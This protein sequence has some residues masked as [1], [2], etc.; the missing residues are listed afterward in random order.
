MDFGILAKQVKQVVA[1]NSPTILTAI[2]VTGTLVTAYLTG[3]AAFK[4]ANVIRDEQEFR[5]R[6]IT[7]D[8]VLT[9]DQ[10]KEA[11]LSSKDKFEVTWK[12]YVPAVV[13]A[14]LTVT[15]IICANRIGTRRAAALATAYKLSEK[16]YSEYKEKVLEKIGPEK[17]KEI[18][19]EVAQDRINKNPIDRRE[20]VVGTGK[21]RCFDTWTNRYFDSSVIAIEAAKNRINNQINNNI[22]ASLSDF[23]HE[24]GLSPTAESD[25]IGWNSDKLMELEIDTAMSEDGVTPCVTIGF[26]VTPVRN[27]ANFH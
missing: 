22:Y 15:T 18:R 3:N 10:A 26:N 19:K 4:A 14:G 11:T 8:P 25:D 16:V 17:E 7:E 1:D 23:Y 5:D 2:S 21:V 6:E 9:T 24:I 12:L 27:Y 13:S 20:I